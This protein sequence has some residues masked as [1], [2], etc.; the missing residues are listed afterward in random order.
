MLSEN[1]KNFD[2]TPI[3]NLYLNMISG[4]LPEDLKESEVNMLKE[5]LGDNWFE[6][7]GYYEPEY[8]RSKYD[9]YSKS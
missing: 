5:Y 8:K 4:L 3:E 1:L 9:T 7:L 2:F 6:E